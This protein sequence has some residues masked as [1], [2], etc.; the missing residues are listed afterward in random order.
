METRLSPRTLS[1]V[2]E[3]YTGE[4]LTDAH[5]SLADV[6]ATIDIFKSQYDIIE[7]NIDDWPENQLLS[8]EGSIRNAAN[9]NEPTYYVFNMGKYKDCE[10][11]DICKKDPQY[12]KWFRDKVASPYTWRLLSKYYKEHRNEQTR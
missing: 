2:Y 12:I 5:N 1:S 4:Y 11:M 3:K 6:K 9:P 7:D 10:F 8:P